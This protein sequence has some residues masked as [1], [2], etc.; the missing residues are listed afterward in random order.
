MV[1]R[2]SA[3]TLVELLVVIAIIAILIGLLLP[4]VQKVR[5]AAA[6]IQDSN[7]LKQIVLAV[8]SCNGVYK[9][10]PPAYGDFPT[11]GGGAGPPAG[12]GTL[13]YFLCPF[14]EQSNVY[15]QAAVTSDNIMNVA[16]PVFLGAADPSMPA[17]GM[18]SMMGGMGSMGGSSYASNYLV[19]GGI[20]G[21]LA[22][23]PQTFADG[24]SNTILFGTNYT[25]C[26]MAQYMWNMGNNGSPPAWPYYYNSSANYLSL[27]LPQMAPIV[28]AC[29][30]MR[31]QSP[32]LGV[33]L[34]GMADGSVQPVSSG[35]SA[36]SWNLALNPA[37][38]QV[39][40]TTW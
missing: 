11:P 15:N 14:L 20:P 19:F 27:P 18:I 34:A 8:H 10:L 35:V 30:P 16:L 29:D 32:Y 4:A 23:I 6:R 9:R 28:A 36:Y 12:T 21:G 1:R 38:G 40:D 31:L 24:T 7:N 17:D 25:Q 2:R 39:F 3:F 13:Q 5:E 22:R 26:G 33:F 37:D